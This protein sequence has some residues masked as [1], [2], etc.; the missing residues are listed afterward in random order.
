MNQVCVECASS[1]FSIEPRHLNG[2][3]ICTGCRVVAPLTIEGRGYGESKDELRAR[4]FAAIEAATVPPVEPVAVEAPA[5]KRAR[6]PHYAVIKAFFSV[7]HAAGLDV[8]SD[9][10]D[11]VRGA[12]GMLLGKRV[13]SRASLTAA[14]WAFATNAVRVGRLFW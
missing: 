5:G 13:E 14:E 12:L 6:C 11:R 7:A 3:V 2:E 4:A 9:G 1:G 8:S 10:K